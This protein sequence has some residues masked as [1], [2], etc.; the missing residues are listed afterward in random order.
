MGGEEGAA[1]QAPL[2]GWVGG[3][4][5][6]WARE[7]GRVGTYEAVLLLYVEVKGFL[8]REAAVRQRLCTFGT[9]ALREMKL[10]V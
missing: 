2:G 5:G 7:E 3:W 9:R 8:A 1:S 10:H 6:A 4:M